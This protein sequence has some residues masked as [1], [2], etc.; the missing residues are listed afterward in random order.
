MVMFDEK[1]HRW[2]CDWTE[3]KAMPGFYQGQPLLS[4]KG[5]ERRW[6]AEEVGWTVA[7]SA[8]KCCCCSCSLVNLVILTFYK[9]LADLCKKAWKRRCLLKMKKKAFILHNNSE[10]SLLR[11][12]SSV[13]MIS[14]IVIISWWWTMVM[15]RSV[16]AVM[17]RR[18]LIGKAEHMCKEAEDAGLKHFTYFVRG[19]LINRVLETR[20][21]G[22]RHVE[23]MSNQT[24]LEHWNQV[25]E[26][27]FISPKSSLLNSRC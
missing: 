12:K 10:G 14:M 27:R 2:L 1:D 18:L 24:W 4:E 22:G 26:T 17:E 5:K 20:F 16:M 6:I 25:F 19:W 9:V 8:A 13:L 7:E 15:R 21:P 23:N 11:W 3:R